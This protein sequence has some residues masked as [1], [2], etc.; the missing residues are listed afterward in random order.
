MA[1]SPLVLINNVDGKV[2]HNSS[3]SPQPKYTDGAVKFLYTVYYAID[4]RFGSPV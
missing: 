3:N 2:L 1:A 4:Q